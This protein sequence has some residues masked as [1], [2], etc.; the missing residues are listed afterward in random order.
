MSQISIHNLAEFNRYFKS[1]KQDPNQVRKVRTLFYKQNFSLDGNNRRIPEDL[2]YIARHNIK[3]EFLTLK[4]R[5][6][7]KIDGA[8][9]LLFKTDDGHAVEAVILRIATGRVSLCLSS[10]AG[11]K[12]SCAFCATGTLGFKRNLTTD[13]IAD[14]II[15]AQRLLK[16]EGRSIRNIVFMG[17][18]E[19][20][21]NFETL[22][23]AITLLTG[24]ESF[25]F[26]PVNIM[27]STCGLADKLVQFA[28]LFPN[29]NI[30]LSLHAVSET[31]RVELMPVNQ[32]HS[33][34]K[35][36]RALLKASAY[37]TRQVMLE[38]LLFKGI[39]DSEEDV[40]RLVAF[41]KGLNVRINLIA[42]NRTSAD[43]QFEAVSRKEMFKFKTNLEKNGLTVTIRYSLGED[44]AAACGQ[45]ACQD[46]E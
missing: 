44:I 25:N 8:T 39:N 45:L 27:V 23:Q 13:E 32:L 42:Y 34:D 16:V 29:V 24:P 31:T 1:Q 12:F 10:Q 40:L 15:H 21:D 18:G 2:L 9:K 35:L 43:D 33:L 41:C 17:M 38:Y 19:P 14:Q 37:S 11:C 30:A 26:A 4:Q 6:D 3:T 46:N 22:C 7:S 36:K 20:F 28:E 5:L